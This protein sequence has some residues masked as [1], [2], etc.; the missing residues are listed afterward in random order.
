MVGSMAIGIRFLGCSLLGFY[1]PKKLRSYFLQPKYGFTLIE[2]LVTVGIII[3]LSAFMIP[4]FNNLGDREELD[5]EANRLAGMIIETRSYAQSPRAVGLGS[6]GIEIN[7]DTNDFL[8]KEGG[9]VINAG[10]I[11]S[12]IS[13]NSSAAI[14]FPVA[15]GGRPSATVPTI[16]LQSA[17]TQAIRY[18]KVNEQ[19][20]NVKICDNPSC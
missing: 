4:A 10:K 12:G 8:I 15:N 7:K 1:V 11:A 19:S 5:N 3:L 14:D 20:G 17:K 9:R 18:I 16:I 6:Y 13:L 2:L